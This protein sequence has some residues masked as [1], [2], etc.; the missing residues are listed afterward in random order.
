MAKSKPSRPS[1]PRDKRGASVSK[2][3][4]GDRLQAWSSHHKTSALVS[5]QKLL[6]TPLQSLMTWLVIGIAMAL[7]SGLF[8]AIDNVK[9]LGERWDGNPRVTV[10]LQRGIKEQAALKLRDKIE[11]LEG[12]AS[13]EYVSPQLA[14]QEF[15]ASSGFGDVLDLLDENPLPPVYIVMPADR[16]VS[17]EELA[18][19]SE[20]LQA[21][22]EVEFVQLDLEWVQR[23]QQIIAFSQRFAFLLGFLLSLGILL[24]VGNTI[25]LAIE[26]R[27]EEIV[28]VK[29]VGGTDAFV[30]RPLLY[31]GL[32]YG[33]VG[34]IVA[35][36]M[37]LV[38]TLVLMGPVRELSAL[39]GSDFSIQGLGFIEVLRLLLIST[40]LGL[41]GSWLA[42]ARHLHLIQ[43]R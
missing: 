23:L 27:R 38:G 25:R 28:V 42:V 21:F 17:T 10:F 26:N 4:W 41:A 37:V 32:W 39:Y 35:W 13:I 9:T 22:A 20:Q 34:G 7:P 2:I 24:T 18:S 16:A 14:L 33:L 5:L 11:A 1:S 19:L 30:R 6:A 12:I 29:L 36:L 15:Q 3:G 43:P 8:L 31:T 40:G